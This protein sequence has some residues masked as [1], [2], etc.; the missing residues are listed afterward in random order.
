MN[1]ILILIPPFFCP[2]LYVYVTPFPERSLLWNVSV[3]TKFLSVM[4]PEKLEHSILFTYSTCLPFHSRLCV[5][6]IT[7]MSGIVE[8]G[9]FPVVP[10][11]DNLKPRPDRRAV[12]SV[13]PHES[14]MR[15]GELSAE[16]WRYDAPQSEIFPDSL[17]YSA[18][19]RLAYIVREAQQQFVV[20]DG[21]T[22][23]GNWDAISDELAWSD[24]GQNYSFVGK[25]GKE[26]FVVGPGDK[27]WKIEGNPLPRRFAQNR[28][29]S[30]IAWLAQ[31]K[32]QQLFVNGQLHWEG[33][34]LIEKPVWSPDGKRLAFAFADEKGAAIRVDGRDFGPYT[35]LLKGSPV[36]SPDSQRCAWVIQR[37]GKSVLVIDGEESVLPFSLVQGGTLNFSPDGSRWAL[38]ARTG[39]LNIKG[40]VVVDGQ[41]GPVYNAL[42]TTPPVWNPAGDAVAYFV[43]LGLKKTFIVCDGR[44]GQHCT[45]FIDGSLTW[46]PE[47]SVVGCIA[48]QD[49][50]SCIVVEARDGRSWSLRPETGYLMRGNSVAFDEGHGLHD[51]G[52]R[53]DGSVFGWTVQF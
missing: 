29:G 36:W 37:K 12:A 27:R 28:D 25:R 24:D 48:Q 4:R 17:V 19:N 45:S 20:V 50:Q 6:Y 47:G 51:L 35:N 31:S 33:P 2:T 40:C 10:S 44:E 21:Q 16:G 49:K 32:H 23:D 52:F 46:N 26:I 7:P 5:L 13:L 9:R 11:P 38:A 34:E 42:G 18:T 43:A 22:Q 1:L 41:S 30:Q 14:K 8:F 15:V 53:E 3:F 39:F